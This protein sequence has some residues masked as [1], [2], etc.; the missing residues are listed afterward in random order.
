MLSV[1]HYVVHSKHL[2]TFQVHVSSYMRPKNP[3]GVIW[4]NA[5]EKSTSVLF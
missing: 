1:S 4:E 3:H 2:T 5:E